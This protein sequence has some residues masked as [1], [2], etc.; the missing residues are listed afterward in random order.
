[1]ASKS[2]DLTDGLSEPAPH[3]VVTSIWTPLVAASAA[4]AMKAHTRAPCAAGSSCKLLMDSLFQLTVTLEL[5]SGYGPKVRKRRRQPSATCP[6]LCRTNLYDRFDP[7]G[8]P[9]PAGCALYE[10]QEDL[11][12]L[13]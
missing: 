12:L 5:H 11:S 10:P 3:H 13:F 4:F 2:H 7:I 9:L 1:M 6:S 8:E